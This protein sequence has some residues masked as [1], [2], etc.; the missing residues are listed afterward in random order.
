MRRRHAAVMPFRVEGPGASVAWLSTGMVDVLSGAL[1][2]VSGWRAISPRSVLARVPGAESDLP[3]VAQIARGLGAGQMVSG[4]VVVVG[5]TVRLRAELYSTVSLRRI[6]APVEARGSIEDPS[7]ALDSLA[8]GL[9]RLRLGTRGVAGGRPPELGTSSPQAMRAAVAAEE[10]MR[11]SRFQEAA[12]SLRAAIR[13]DSGLAAAYYRLWVANTFGATITPWT[14]VAVVETALARPERLSERQRRMLLAVQAML[15]GQRLSTL[16]LGQS[17]G[18]MFPDDAEAAYVEGEVGFHFG[19]GLAESPLRA[20]R[21]F[22]RGI[23]LDSS[24]TDNYNHAIELRFM[25]GDTA[26]A[27]ALLARGLA[28]QPDNFILHATR[29]ADRVASG[30]DARELARTLRAERS[31]AEGILGRAPV[32]AS[33]IFR[34]DPVRAF[35]VLE[36]TAAAL[37]DAAGSRASRALGMRLE[38]QLLAGRGRR[39]AAR[40]A[41]EAVTVFSGG[42]GALVAQLDLIAGASTWPDGLADPGANL[43]FL[44]AAVASTRRGWELLMNGDSAAARSAL[45]SAFGA[46]PYASGDIEFTL[47][48]GSLKLGRLDLA[49]GAPRLAWQHSQEGFGVTSWPPITAEFEELRGMI[50]EQLANREGAIQGYRNF[51]TL[52]AQADPELQPRVA[53]ARAAL[54]RLGAR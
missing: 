2:G 30:E 53:A 36:A 40:D 37:Q 51:V 21:A 15:Q 9:S 49:A 24:L 12:D 25:T 10:L 4:S 23:A 18:A 14:Q 1:D 6:G 3:R 27:R 52:W 28:R 26:E 35:A 38:A 39:R 48:M 42:P 16:D 19:L 44:A 20:L 17:V 46:R 7:R 43:P 41:L 8:T 29:F 5:R 13:H 50:A 54:A 45:A 34:T 22:E 33:R 47:L 11:R 31:D 32:Q